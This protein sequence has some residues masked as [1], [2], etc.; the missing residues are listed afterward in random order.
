MAASSTVYRPRNPQATDYYRCLDDHLESF[1]Q[2]YEE[3]FERSYGFFRPYLRK[4][5][6]RYLEC[7]N[8]RNGFAR[9]KCG[10]AITSTFWPSPASADTFAPP[11]IRSG[12]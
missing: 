8:L 9:V 6:Y 4:V 5:I 2:G 7:G 12:W 11:A 10:T 1:I 3:Q